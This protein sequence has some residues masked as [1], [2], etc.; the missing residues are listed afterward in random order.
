M[1]RIG[2]QRWLVMLIACVPC[3]TQGAWGQAEEPN[4]GGVS[5]RRAPSGAPQTPAPA[6]WLEAIEIYT[7]PWDP[8]WKAAAEGGSFPYSFRRSVKD[9]ESIRD[10]P[11][12]RKKLDDDLRAAADRLMPLTVVRAW[13]GIQ[14]KEV[15]LIFGRGQ[16]A[17]ADRLAGMRPLLAVIDHSKP[18]DDFQAVRTTVSEIRPSSRVPSE[19][20]R[21]VDAPD[22][23]RVSSFGEIDASLLAAPVKVAAKKNPTPGSG[24]LTLEVES[25]PDELQIDTTYPWYAEFRLFEMSKD[26]VR[27]KEVRFEGAN[28]L[29]AARNSRRSFYLD[30]IDPA[31][32]PSWEVALGRVEVKS[33]KPWGYEAEIVKWYGVAPKDRLVPDPK[34]ANKAAS[35]GA[36]TGSVPAD[37]TTAP[38]PLPEEPTTPGVPDSDN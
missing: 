24:L 17:L 20:V 7:L 35:K 21:V 4:F 12:K 3:L 30:P 5:G 11:S 38:P 8:D 29:V 13:D 1:G 26:G 15:I 31:R 22:S 37:N 25:P 9:I 23:A 19:L 36:A 18:G 33:P 16:R 32:R 6:T 10:N 28:S 27:G 34:K 2:F 14:R